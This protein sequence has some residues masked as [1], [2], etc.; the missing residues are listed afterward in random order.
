[1]YC[2]LTTCQELILLHWTLLKTPPNE[3]VIPP[4]SQKR[5]VEF[6]EVTGVWKTVHLGHSSSA[7]FLLFLCAETTDP[8]R[9]HLFLRVWWQGQ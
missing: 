9:Q 6:G 1:M 2:A 8:L 3:Y 4:V 5:N 7:L